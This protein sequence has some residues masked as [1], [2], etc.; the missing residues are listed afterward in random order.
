[1]GPISLNGKGDPGEVVP[2]MP[3]RCITFTELLLEKLLIEFFNEFVIVAVVVGNVADEMWITWIG[4]SNMK[5]Y[6]VTYSNI[7]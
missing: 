5:I 7:K 6:L 1:M 2:E 4:T 3:F